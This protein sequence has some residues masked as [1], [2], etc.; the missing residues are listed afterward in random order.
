M[1]SDLLTKMLEGETIVLGGN[2][3]HMGG[4]SC[5]PDC[6]GCEQARD[7]DARERNRHN[8]LRG[9]VDRVQEHDRAEFYGELTAAIQEHGDYATSTA[10]YLSGAA[11]LQT[12]QSF[13][14]I[15]KKYSP[16]KE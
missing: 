7:T 15:A 3:S 14:V 16:E 11:T 12:L 2:S 4:P 13:I 9:V 6:K 10:N 1:M 5:P 8:D